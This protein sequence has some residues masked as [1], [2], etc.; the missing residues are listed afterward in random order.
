M[1]KSKLFLKII[2]CKRIQARTNK[3]KIILKSLIYN[4]IPLLSFLRVL[5][6]YI[7]NICKVVKS[8][9]KRVFKL[10]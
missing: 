9:L 4:L 10:F 3:Q 1:V 5:K 8:C 6:D 7:Y 2:L